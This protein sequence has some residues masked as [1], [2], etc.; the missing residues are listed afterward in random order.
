MGRP[1][2][3]TC[4]DGEHE[5]A[6]SIATIVQGSTGSGVCDVRELP[7]INAANLT[8][9]HTVQASPVTVPGALGSPFVQQ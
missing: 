6:R 4:L 9:V 5:T 1:S 2:A 7:R 8:S 3:V